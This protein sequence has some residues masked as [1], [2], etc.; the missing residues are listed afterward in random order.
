MSERALLV[1]AGGWSRE[2]WID[3]V[4]PDFKDKIELLPSF[5]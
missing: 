2:H 4:L 5:G 3:V 1:G